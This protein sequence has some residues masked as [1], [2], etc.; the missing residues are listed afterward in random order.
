ML[1]PVTRSGAH[2]QIGGVTTRFSG[3]N[4]YWLGLDDNARVNF[5]SHTT[6]TSETS[7][8][9]DRSVLTVDWSDA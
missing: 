4:C 1:T 3:M 5:P 8:I 2:L 7:A 6:I 9:S